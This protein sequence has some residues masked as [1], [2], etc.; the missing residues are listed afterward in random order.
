LSDPTPTTPPSA[1][2]GGSPADGG[3]GACPDPCTS[4]VF[5]ATEVNKSVSEVIS[6]APAPYTAWNN[7]YSWQTKFTL[8]VSRTPCTVHVTVKIKVTGTISATQKSAWKSS[9]ESK[10]NGKAKLMC[11]DP[12]CAT[13]C[14]SG[15]KIIVEVQFVTSGEHYVVAANSAAAGGSRSVTPDMGTWGVNDTVDVTHEFGH[16]LGA[17]EEYFTTNGVDYTSG[18]T[19]PGFRAPG[20]GVMNNPAGAPL[21]GN[22]DLIRQEAGRVMGVT[23]T[24]QTQ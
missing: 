18:G 7:T 4:K 20:A 14:P 9:I 17:P 19:K 16:M 24:A 2:N 23:C 8:Q 10:W 6:N 5:P 11:P 15:Y 21:P 1:G 22:Y 13:A 3:A 12:A